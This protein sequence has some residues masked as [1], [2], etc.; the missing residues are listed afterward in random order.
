M[1]GQNF[2]EALDQYKGTKIGMFLNGGQFVEGTLLDIK[3]DHVAIENN[4]KVVYYAKEQI[5]ALSRSTKYVEPTVTFEMP[6]SN[7]KQLHEVLAELKY[8]W[9]TIT[10]ISSQTF[11]GFLSRIYDDHIVIINKENQFM[12]PKAFILNVQQGEIEKKSEEKSENQSQDNSNKQAAENNQAKENEY[13]NDEKK[14]EKVNDNDPYFPS[15][16]GN[17]INRKNREE[18]SSNEWSCMDEI[19]QRAMIEAQFCSLKKQAERNRDR[20]AHCCSLSCVERARLEEQYCSLMKHADRQC[21][22]LRDC[23]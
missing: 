12:I 8:K 21:Q 22:C 15:E 20:V 13:D 2:S 17:G 3:E 19:A 16:V 9:I 5:H 10:S 11:T 23:C 6:T 14:N 18:C 1:S 7:P 4:L